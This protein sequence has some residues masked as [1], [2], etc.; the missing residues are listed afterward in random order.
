MNCIPSLIC[1]YLTCK[2]E[3]LR[4]SISSFLSN[5]PDTADIDQTADV[6]LSYE[7][8][9]IE[10]IHFQL[11]VHTA[12][13]PFEGLIIDLKVN[14]SSVMAATVSGFLELFVKPTRLI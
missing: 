7:L 9:L 14:L 2:T 1:V 6:L 13:R 11:V 10:K 3:E 12:Y 5:I 8:L 4:I